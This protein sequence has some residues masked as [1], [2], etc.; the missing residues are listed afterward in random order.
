MNIT[1]LHHVF[2][3][4][5]GIEQVIMDL[6]QQLK[7]MGHDA[8]VITYNNS[9]SQND[10]PIAEFKL[11]RSTRLS[12]SVLAPM[13]ME[14]NR[15]IRDTLDGSDVV[16]T[17]LYPMSV[18]PLWPRK[19]KAKVVFIEWGIQPYSAYKSLIDKVYLWLL[20]RAD[21]YAI[22]R[23]DKVIVANDVTKK[24]VEKQGVEPV[25]LNLYGINFDRLKATDKPSSNG[26]TIMYAGRQSPHKNIGTLIQAVGM[27]REQGRNIKL[28]IVGRESFPRYARRLRMTVTGL[29]LEDSII[30]TGLVSEDD[31][32]R[33][34]SVCD[35]FVN[36]SSWEGYLIA[37]PYAFKKPI[38]AYG[39]PPH[40]ET[41][42]DGVTGLLT[43]SLAPS[44][45]ANKIQY[46][47][48]HP[49]KMR[50]MGEA[51]YKWARENLDYGVIA[52]KFVKVLEDIK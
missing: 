24:W 25:K 40:D 52:K 37:E 13:F 30:F 11:P 18:V 3:S 9:M 41:V 19:I 15:N 17:S 28:L 32:V 43:D 23:S 42:Q 4:G 33:Y 47:L 21:R 51:G 10:I 45:F 29:G 7:P 26:W 22:K 16:V 34:Y 12:E 14:T 6:C 20:N 50:T 31:L 46:L 48:T 36:A 8:S 49:E 27:L 39:V 2:Q 38:I 5:S 44:E 35:I 1:F